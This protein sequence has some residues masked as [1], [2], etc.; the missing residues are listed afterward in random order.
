[1]TRASFLFV[2]LLAA[3]TAQAQ[4]GRGG[5]DRRDPARAQLESEFRRRFAQQVRE[6]VGLSE[7]QMRRLGP[8]QQRLG[9]ERQRIQLDEQAT[10]IE[11]RRNLLDS[12]P[13]DTAVSRALAR[14]VEIEKRKVAILETEQRE[15]AAI[16][17][18]VQRA[19]FMAMQEQM[20]RLLDEQRRPMRRDDS[21][22]PRRGRP[23]G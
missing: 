3:A 13:S 6:R 19:R 18:P 22:P 20:R 14:L 2:A 16:M 4:P 10:R 17:S 5:G 23:P 8:I 1:M 21:P 11:L 7:D 9:A 12:V 15:L